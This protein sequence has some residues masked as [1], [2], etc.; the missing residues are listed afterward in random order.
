[1]RKIIAVFEIIGGFFVLFTLIILL[2][3][4][5]AKDLS[6]SHFGFPF[7]SVFLAMTFSALNFAAGLGLWWN[8]KWGY[9]TSL[10]T[11]IIQLIRIQTSSF[12]YLFYSPL[13]FIIS[14]SKI[15][16]MFFFGIGASFFV[17]FAPQPV[18]SIFIGVNLIA[19]GI[20]LLIVYLLR[21]LKKG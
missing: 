2:F 7:L 12:H 10:L 15:G 3:F 11:Q 13:G 4:F 14:V 18:A 20:L 8:K 6:T 16:T 21:K 19:V 5:H 1:M 17:S 9:I